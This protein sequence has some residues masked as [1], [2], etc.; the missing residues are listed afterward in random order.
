VN[1][2]SESKDSLAIWPRP[3][4]FNNSLAETT[5]PN[6]RVS[7][8]QSTFGR[9]LAAAGQRLLRPGVIDFNGSTY[10]LTS[11]DQSGFFSAL[12]ARKR[13]ADI[14]IIQSEQRESKA[15]H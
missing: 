9:H 14:P 11:V 7:K 12:N 15:T 2:P 5:E 8:A 13:A 1:V 10:G 3:H 4:E 6:T